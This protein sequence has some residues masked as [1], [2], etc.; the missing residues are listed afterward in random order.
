MDS[1]NPIPPWR[2]HSGHGITATVLG[3]LAICIL[4]LNITLWLFFRAE[5]N[6]T[7]SNQVILTSL[8]VFNL[9]V[10]I[11]GAVN[12]FKG[13]RES[14]RKRVLPLIGLALNLFV[15]LFY[16]AGIINWSLK[17]YY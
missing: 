3:S 8:G 12:G 16:L 7:Y 17:R 15:F 1:R 9:V 4:L 10:I 11:F 5:G 6:L 13:I 14:A 2:E